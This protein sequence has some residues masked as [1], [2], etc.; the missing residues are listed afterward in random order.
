MYVVQCLPNPLAKSHYRDVR[1]RRSCPAESPCVVAKGIS[2]LRHWEW[3]FAVMGL[4]AYSKKGGVAPLRSGAG[5]ILIARA[6]A[7]GRRD[8]DDPVVVWWT[9]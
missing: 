4:F 3:S 2:T 6:A 5:R 1:R 8:G 7:C 9:K